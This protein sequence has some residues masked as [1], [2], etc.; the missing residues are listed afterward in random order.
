M[1]IELINLWKER[2]HKASTDLIEIGIRQHVTS[3][4]Y[5]NTQSLI[6][7]LQA[8]ICDEYT[9]E[10]EAALSGFDFIH[11]V[12]GKCLNIL[13]GTYD[14]YDAE[15][16]V[17]IRFLL[18]P[19]HFVISDNMPYK[20]MCEEW[21]EHEGAGNGSYFERRFSALPSSLEDSPA[22]DFTCYIK[23]GEPINICA[24][25]SALAKKLKGRNIVLQPC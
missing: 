15:D 2:L 5:K 13:R 22:V 10:I 19:F 6:D 23:A 11:S 20:A 9:D 25:F 21:N 1:N 16:L 17:H 18:A 14:A 12:H 4:D 8:C 7:E 3:D 24:F